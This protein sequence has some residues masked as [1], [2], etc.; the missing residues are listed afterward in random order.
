MVTTEQSVFLFIGNDKYLKEDA[1]KSLKSTLPEKFLHGSDQIIFYGGELDEREVFDHLNS[2]PLLSD[3]RLVVIRDV[4]KVSDEFKASLIKYIKKPSKSAYL[5]L[6]AQNYSV[7]KDYDEVLNLINVRKL[8]PPAGGPLSSWVRDYARE[9]GKTITDDA[10]LILREL[11]GNDLSYLSQELDKLITFVGVRK[12]IK[13]DDVE[14]IIGRSSVTS[15]FDI[16]DAIGRK[17][18]AGAIRIT[19][20]LVMSGRKEY[21]I[22]GLLTWHLRRMLKAKAMKD[23]G[24]SDYFIASILKIGRKFQDE[25]F[26]QLA[27]LKRE[28]IRSNIEILLQTDLDM[29][30]AKFDTGAVLEFAIIRLCLL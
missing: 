29:K 13:S 26:R 10:I 7:L 20:S 2:I 5:I 28:K 6:D 8:D 24:D 14:E 16:A 3:K 23:K 11:E 21:E 18:T 17:D 25:F 12:E 4:E 22:I 27:G 9:S 30:R 1:L 19:S 15:A